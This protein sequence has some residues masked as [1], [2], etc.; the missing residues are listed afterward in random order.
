MSLDLPIQDHLMK[1]NGVKAEFSDI[2]CGI[3]LTCLRADNERPVN[4]GRKNH[5]GVFLNNDNKEY[6]NLM[7]STF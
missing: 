1:P 5:Y 4:S 2:G 3:I 6:C 7:K